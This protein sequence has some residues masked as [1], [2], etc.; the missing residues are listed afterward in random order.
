MAGNVN[1]LLDE[2]HNEETRTR[3]FNDLKNSIVNWGLDL[4]VNSSDPLSAKLLEAYNA[5]IIIGPR[6]WRREYDWKVEETRAIIQF[7][8][9]GGTLI[10]TPARGDRNYKITFAREIGIDW[11]GMNS[12]FATDFT[13]HPITSGI[14]K[15]HAP[16]FKANIIPEWQ[17]LARVQIGLR[18]FP[19][20]AVR[21]FGKGKM[22]FVSSINLFSKT[23]LKRFDNAK[24]LLNMFT[25]IKELG[26]G[27]G[28]KKKKPKVEKLVVS[29]EEKAQVAIKLEA[30][31]KA[32][33]CPHCGVE[34]PPFAVFCPNC[35][36]SMEE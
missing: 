14:F 21:D 34:V 11:L 29:E 35:G 24:M 33:F 27:V 15:I 31:G 9:D 23:F 26:E 19:I 6:R 20:L 30:P 5:L 22:V 12:K 1:I 28:V 18:S 13:L 10:V 36:A 4:Y 8:E 25:W 7:V 16:W 3:I 32:K 17:Q 2:Y